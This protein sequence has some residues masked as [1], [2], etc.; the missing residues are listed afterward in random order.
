M[1]TEPGLPQHRDEVPPPQDDSPP[2]PER[3]LALSDGVVAIALTLLILDL[4]VPATRLLR[5][6]TR[7]RTWPRSS[8]TIPTS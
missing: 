4:K 8:G 3:L 6:P 1:S 2:G 7:P 5:H